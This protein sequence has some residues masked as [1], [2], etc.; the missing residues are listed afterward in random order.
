MNKKRYYGV[1]LLR[2]ISMIL[3]VILHTLGAGGVLD[4]T[5]Q[6]TMTFS[7]VWLLE[8]IAYPAVN[9]FAM[10]SGFVGYSD[11]VYKFKYSNCI[12]LWIRIVFYGIISTVVIYF[13]NSELV[14]TGDFFR[15]F[16]PITTRAYWYYTAYVVLVVLIPAI[17]FVLRSLDKKVLFSLLI[18]IFLLSILETTTKQFALSGGYGFTWLALLYVLGAIIKKCKLHEKIKLGYALTALLMSILI[19]WI[20]LLYGREISLFNWEIDKE[21]FISYVSPTVLCSA[22]MTLIIFAK[23]EFCDKVN[24][25]IKLIRP[26]VFTTFIL[27]SQYSIANNFLYGKF[28]FLANTRAVIVPVFVIGYAVTFF[29][30]STLIDLLRIYIFKFAK[31]DSLSKKVESGIKFLLDKMSSLVVD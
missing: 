21:L 31:V 13:V 25:I 14:S 5:A 28:V 7:V 23:V 15:V 27:N 9:I 18:L 4:A 11:E 12:S 16:F 26:C 2:C 30:V 1:D 3:V 6:G 8:I 22:V 24:R 29:V 20:W 19:T 17:N 10:I